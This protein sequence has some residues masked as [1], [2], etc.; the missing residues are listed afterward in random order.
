[1]CEI[2]AAELL[3]S[4]LDILIRESCVRR[5]MTE[6]IDRKAHFQEIEVCNA[7]LEKDF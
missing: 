3:A 2:G 6:G 1:M 5:A 4:P 7:T